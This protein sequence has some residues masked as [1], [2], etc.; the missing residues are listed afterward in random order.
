MGELQTKHNCDCHM[1][2]WSS[3]VKTMTGCNTVINSQWLCVG[4]SKT[5]GSARLGLFSCE[6]P[7]V[8][9][10]HPCLTLGSNSNWRKNHGVKEADLAES[11]PSPVKCLR[12]SS[13]LSL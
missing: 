11:N 1:K 5:F 9:D 6:F 10:S 12:G 3:K 7:E 4:F 8:S 13:A 2:K